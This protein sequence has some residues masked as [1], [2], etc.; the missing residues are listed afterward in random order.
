MDARLPFS[1]LVVGTLAP[2]FEYVLRL[3]PRGSFAHSVPGLLLF[4]V[5][6]SYL[7]WVTYDRVIRPPVV[8][9]LPDAVASGLRER[10]PIS[11]PWVLLALLLGAASHIVWDAFTHRTGWVVQ[12]LSALQRPIFPE[13]AGDLP[14]YSVL[15]HGSTFVGAL[16]IAVAGLHWQRRYP[17][18]VGRRTPRQ[19]RRLVRCVWF[20]L[21]AAFAAAVLNRSRA[22]GLGLAPTLGYAA[23][24]AMAGFALALLV[25]GISAQR[26]VG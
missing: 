4:C 24:G 22:F 21:L 8:A 9:L 14:V 10:P 1:A 18:A 25:Y 19:R 3:A 7:V 5:P 17:A 13:L 23:V 15:Q 12:H 11:T 2:D 26:D 6:V 16:L 20:V